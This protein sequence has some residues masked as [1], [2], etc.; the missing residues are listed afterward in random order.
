M[1]VQ[2]IKD[3]IEGTQPELEMCKQTGQSLM[4]LCGEPDKPEIK[5]NI[6]DLDQVWESVNSTCNQREENLLDVRLFTCSS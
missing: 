4:N 2:A 5:K 6:E 1:F 3:E